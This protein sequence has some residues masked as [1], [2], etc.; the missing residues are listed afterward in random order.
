MNRKWRMSCNGVQNIERD[1]FKFVMIDD[2]LI[3]RFISIHPGIIYRL[4]IHLAFINEPSSNKEFNSACPLSEQCV[5]F[6]MKS[7]LSL[8]IG[9]VV[10]LY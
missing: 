1:F 8:V 3:S 9:Q 10:L 2:P 4:Q 5:C 7:S 6:G